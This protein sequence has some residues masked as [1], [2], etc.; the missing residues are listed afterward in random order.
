MAPS[1]PNPAAS[2]LADPEFQAA[3]LED[4]RQVRVRTGKLACRWVVVLMALGSALDWCYYRDY[5]GTFL[6][7]RAVC[8]LLV[9]LVW[10]WHERPLTLDQLSRLQLLIVW[11]PALF[12]ELM[13]WWARDPYSGYYAG[14]S[15]ILVAIGAAGHWR[16]RDTIVSVSGVLIA[17]GALELILSPQGQPT[18]PDL[19]GNNLFFLILTSVLVV[20]GNHKFNELALREFEARFELD[21]NRRTLEEANAK[22]VEL[23]RVKSRFFANIS[24]ELRTPLTLLLAPLESMLNDTRAGFDSQ[25]REYLGTMHAN[26]LRLLKLVNDLLELVRLESGRMEIHREP[27]AIAE[28]LAGLMSSVRKVAVDKHVSLTCAVPEAVGTVV[29]DRDKLEK[30]L[31]NLVFNA[32]KFTPAGGKVTV[33]A[34]A[35]NDWL[36]F[37][38]RDTGVGITPEQLPLVFQRFWQSDTSPKR[39]FQGAGIGLALVKELVEIQSGS[40]GVASQVR[41]GTVFTVQ[42]PCIRPPAAQ[43]V[44][45][46]PEG[47]E[48][49]GSDPDLLRQQSEEWTTGLYRRAELFPGM[50]SIKESPRPVES[51]TGNRPRVLIADDEPD[52]LQFLRLQ[53]GGMF[54]VLEAVDGQQAV[55]KAAQFLPNAILCDMMMPGKDGLQ[56]CREVREHAATQGIPLLLITARADEETKLAALAAGASDFLSKPFS[57]TE[58]KVRLRNLIESHQVHQKLRRQNL[59]LE[60]TIEQLKETETQLIASEKMACLGRLSAGIMH[61]INNPLNYMKTGVHLLR[62]RLA[63]LPPAQRAAF[64]ELGTDLEDGVGRVQEI[65]AALRNFAHPSLERFEFVPLAAV[66]SVVLKLLSND[67]KDGVRLEQRLAPDHRVWGNQNKLVQVLLNLVQN[68]VYAAKKKP[69]GAGEPTVWLESRIVADHD[70]VL[71]R[72]NGPGIAPEHLGKIFEPF[73]TTKD[74]GE[75][76]GLGLSICYRIIEEHQGRI[77]VQSEP[78]QYCEFTIEIPRRADADRQ[79]A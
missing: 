44:A 25:V 2:H 5:L 48:P 79:A 26:G 13:I 56:V 3:Y 74:V 78:G 24:H 35:D 11:L 63:A 51:P 45:P 16:T 52:M 46:L 17:Y 6:A 40:V 29:T 15:L 27:V 22:L 60:S 66:V 77:R 10:L 33:E 19:L 39:R 54:Q 71:V 7:M 75:G 62:S 42:L 9:G 38:V 12:L 58:L 76:M 50:I 31:L 34:A 41:A 36:H 53:L 70:V 47:I 8:S 37:Q 55:D 43:P 14:L 69:D 23:D 18:G 61:E 59:I 1:L 21:R 73:F 68:A 28:F 20:V 49:A 64:E 4:Q 67:L 32:L 57:I 30:I 65:V 72:D